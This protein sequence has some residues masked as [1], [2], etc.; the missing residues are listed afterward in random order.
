MSQQRGITAPSRAQEGPHRSKGQDINLR[1]LGAM[2]A[3]GAC[4]GFRFAGSATDLMHPKEPD[5]AFSPR[6]GK[7]AGKLFRL[8]KL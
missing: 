1:Y 2:S 7:V 8:L 4:W 5:F 3:F 6:E